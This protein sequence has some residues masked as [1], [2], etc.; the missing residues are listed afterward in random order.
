M[1][2]EL[3][4]G[5]VFD[6]VYKVSEEWEV[7]VRQQK[8][9]IRIFVDRNGRY[10]YRNNLSSRSSVN[11][12]IHTSPKCYKTQEEALRFAVKEINAQLTANK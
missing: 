9:R 5:H 4:D 12:R 2:W 1:S 11:K 10:H 7:R 6:E 8:V 3:F